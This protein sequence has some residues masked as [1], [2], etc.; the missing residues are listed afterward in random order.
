MAENVFFCFWREIGT[1]WRDKRKGKR[2]G[3]TQN[4]RA[5]K[6]VRESQRDREEKGRPNEEY[7]SCPC[8]VLHSCFYF[9]FF[10]SFVFLLS[11]SLS[12]SCC[13]FLLLFLFL[14]LFLYYDHRRDRQ[15]VY[16]REAA[17]KRRSRFRTIHSRLDA[18]IYMSIHLLPCAQC[19][20]CSGFH[21]ASFE[22]RAK[23]IFLFCSVL[24]IRLFFFKIFITIFFLVPL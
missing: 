10:F 3:K 1:R 20:T 15:I 8:V 16:I 12:L 22:L 18:F 21:A 23:R 6:R 19:K 14:P 7:E 2:G 5:K 17:K 24:V 4:E 11:L 9:I 13:C